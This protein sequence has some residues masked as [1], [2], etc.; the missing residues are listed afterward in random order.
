M[1]YGAVVKP[2]KGT[3]YVPP[4]EEYI[5]HL[6]QAA[7]PATVKEGTRASVLVQIADED[8][9]VV[10]TLCAGRLDT[11]P[12]DQYISEYAEFTVSGKAEVH[13]T[14]YYSPQFGDQDEEEDEG[15][16]DEDEDHAINPYGMVDS[17]EYEDDD[18]DEDE[19]EDDEDDEDE[20]DEDEDMADGHEPS[21]IIEDIT[22]QD[23]Q[24]PNGRLCA[25]LAHTLQP[26]AMLQ[27]V[28]C[29]KQSSGADS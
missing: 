24:V 20:D 25:V 6:S 27:S 16:D 14:G 23:Q 5:L 28:N 9:I 7:L 3:V 19:D 17:D 11:V 10:C 4:P 15:E 29:G 13:L 21:V 22:E 8:P 18:D 1:F 26:S 12:L 2:D